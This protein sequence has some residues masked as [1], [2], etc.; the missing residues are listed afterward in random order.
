M[1]YVGGQ[2]L[3]KINLLQTVSVVIEKLGQESAE[4]NGKRPKMSLLIHS[5]TTVHYHNITFASMN[6]SIPQLSASKIGTGA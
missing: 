6:I 2:G 4:R 1:I 3:I 5:S